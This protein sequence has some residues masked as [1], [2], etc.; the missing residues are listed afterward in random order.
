MTSMSDFAGQPL[1]WVKRLKGWDLMASENSVIATFP[2]ETSGRFAVGMKGKRYKKAKAIIPDGTGALFLNEEGQ[3]IAIYTVEQGPR[4]ATY[5]EPWLEFPDGRKFNWSRAGFFDSLGHLNYAL[6]HRSYYGAGAW[7]DAKGDIP[8]VVIRDAWSK[9]RVDI[10][11][12]AA[13]LRDPELS[14]LLVLGLY[15]IFIE[16]R[17]GMYEMRP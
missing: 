14:L 11:Q 4:L 16:N 3:D 1:T 9:H 2:V 17:Q 6:K 8:Y 12:A 10:Y 5:S 7:Q 15:N 13:E